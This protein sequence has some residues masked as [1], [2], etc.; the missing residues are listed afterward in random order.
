MFPEDQM[1]GL[2]LLFYEGYAGGARDS[3]KT[4]NP[5][6]TEVKVTTVGT[7]CLKIAQVRHSFCSAVSRAITAEFQNGGFPLCRSSA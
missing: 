3:E 6:I 7:S 1:K 5:D 4:F 2:L